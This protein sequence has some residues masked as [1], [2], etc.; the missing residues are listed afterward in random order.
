MIPLILKR[1]K[2]SRPS[3]QWRDDDYDVLENGKVVGRFFCLDAVG[4]HGRAWMWARGHNGDIRR[5]K[6]GERPISLDRPRNAFFECS[7]T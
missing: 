2:F 7:V 3:G 1:A 4:A 5:A 6:A